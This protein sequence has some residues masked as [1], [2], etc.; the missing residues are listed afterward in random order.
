MPERVAEDIR[1][2]IA[3][4]RQRLEESREALMAELRSFVPVVVVGLVALGAITA[5]R[6]VRGG[7]RLIRTLS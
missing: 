6:G 7:I 3:A 1:R 4:E 2:D 5:R